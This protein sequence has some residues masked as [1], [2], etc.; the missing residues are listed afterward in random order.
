MVQSTLVVYG[1]FQLLNG[2]RLSSPRRTDPYASTYHCEY[3]TALQCTDNTGRNAKFR[4]F[5]PPG[6]V[7]EPPGTVSFVQAR[8]YI[9]LHGGTVLLEGV[10]HAAL[11]GQPT[12]DNY[13]HQAPNIIFTMIYGIGVVKA[14]DVT[15]ANSESKEFHVEVSPWVRDDNM[16]CVVKYVSYI[17]LSTLY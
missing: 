16:T 11:P 7:A 1:F 10:R 3:D 2:T 5:S 8:A 14:P 17:L 9:P 4:M 12:D 6:E 13:Q 15:N